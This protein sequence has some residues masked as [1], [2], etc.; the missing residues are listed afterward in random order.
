MIT[1]DKVEVVG[2]PQAIRGMRNPYNSWSKSDS[3]GANIGSAD[4][5]LATKLAEA[6]TDHGKFL[7]FIQ[8]YADVVGPLYWWKEA[9]TYRIGVEKDSCSTMHNI[10]SKKF[11]H[12]DF[13]IEHLSGLPLRVF[14]ATILQLN[15]AREEYL[16]THDKSD[17][18][19]MIQMLPSSYNQKRTM[20]FSYA[21]LRNIYHARKNHLLDEWHTFCDWIET[22]PYSELIT[23]ELNDNE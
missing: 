14:D 6:G 4:L 10:A 21:A 8:V 9:D 17:W 13:S 19:A 18:W 3:D 23:G 12:E 2:I 22:L 16:E 5:K 15:L 11:T 7:R 20:M 1:I